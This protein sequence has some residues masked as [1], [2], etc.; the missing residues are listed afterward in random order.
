MKVTMAVET[1]EWDPGRA[2]HRPLETMRQI[3]LNA[4]AFADNDEAFYTYTTEHQL[5]INEVVYCL[6]AYEYRGDA[7][8]EAMR[9]PILFHPRWPVQA[10]KIVAKL[11]DEHYGRMHPT[12]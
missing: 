8:L 4:L 3:A 12:R 1:E 10:I 7:G 5:T 9:N 11:L 2:S 6:N